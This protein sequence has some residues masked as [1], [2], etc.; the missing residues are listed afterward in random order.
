L[1]CGCLR[2]ICGLGGG[3]L[4]ARW[5][6]LG[7]GRSGGRL[8]FEIFP[9]LG[10]G[11]GQVDECVLQAGEANL[12]GVEFFG[13][14]C[15]SRCALRKKRLDESVGCEEVEHVCTGVHGLVRVGKL[16]GV[17]VSKVLQGK[18]K[19]GTQRIMIAREEFLKLFPWP[20]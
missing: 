5:L 12:E 14:G 7:S 10:C 6:G 18:A 11:L 19:D 20:G 3:A 15:G 9:N 1:Q 4:V 17:Q 13:R 2:G 8:G 16:D